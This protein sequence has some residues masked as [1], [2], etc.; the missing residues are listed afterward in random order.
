MAAAILGG[1]CRRRP[2]DI[3]LAFPVSTVETGDRRR[4]LVEAQKGK[5]RGYC[6][7]DKKLLS[8]R[9]ICTKFITPAVVGAGWD[10]MSQ[11]REEYGFTKGRIIVRGKLAH[12]AGRG[13]IAR[14]APQR[15]HRARFVLTRFHCSAYRYARRSSKNS[16][17]G[18]TLVT[19]R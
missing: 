1:N 13:I 18:S 16:D 14:R 5:T 15:N 3:I 8:E 7:V 4:W 12:E 2:P 11:L 9:D 19:S 17:A 6:R 10:A